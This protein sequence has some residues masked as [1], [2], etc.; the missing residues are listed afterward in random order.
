[1][2]LANW[3][4]SRPNKLP[5]TRRSGARPLMGS[6]AT[7]ILKG[8]S[9]LTSLRTGLCHRCG[10]ASNRRIGEHIPG[11]SRDRAHRVLTL[12]A[13]RRRAAESDPRNFDRG[14]IVK[15]NGDTSINLQ[16]GGDHTALV[17]L[18]W[19]ELLQ[20]LSHMVF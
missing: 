19:D 12:R 13:L 4:A 9:S 14:S 7:S 3:A 5:G 16:K 18:L 2:S 10:K 6:S 20:R 17:D 1:M 11:I 15:T 8:R